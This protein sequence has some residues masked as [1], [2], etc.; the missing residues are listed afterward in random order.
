M[1]GEGEDTCSPV[2]GVSLSVVAMGGGIGPGTVVFGGIVAGEKAGALW[3]MDRQ[4]VDSWA[5]NVSGVWF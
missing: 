5:L 1:D 2:R 4:T 3:G